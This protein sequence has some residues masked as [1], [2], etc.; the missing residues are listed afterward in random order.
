MKTLSEV[1]EWRVGATNELGD[2]AAAVAQIFA[3]FVPRLPARAYQDVIAGYEN[4][5]LLLSFELANV[6]PLPIDAD[7]PLYDEEL[8]RLT[9][10]GIRNV[11]PGFWHL[12]PSL[13]IPGVIHAFVCIYDVPAVAP[14]ENRIIV[15]S[16]F[17]PTV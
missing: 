1:E 5:S 16:S 2:P 3:R 6:V 14:W 11:C 8:R 12:T 17:S 4:G 7:G 13:N 9:A 15:V 10:F